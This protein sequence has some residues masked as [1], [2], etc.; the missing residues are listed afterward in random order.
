MSKLAVVVAS[1]RV[2]VI[3]AVAVPATLPSPPPASTSWADWLPNATLGA[4]V[5][6]LK[7]KAVAAETLPARS[8]WRTCT[9][10]APWL[11]VGAVV[12]TSATATLAWAIHRHAHSGLAPAVKS[13]LVWGLALT[14][15]LTLVTAG[16]LSGMGSHWVGGT[17]SD[18]GG[19]ALTGWS[20][21]GGDL[22][23]AHFFATHAMHFIPLAGWLLARAGGSAAPTLVRVTALAYSGFIAWTFMQALRGQPFL[24][25]LGT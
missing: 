17:P 11:G 9:E 14:L 10:L 21:D 8:L 13:G 4:P 18:A 16:T 19:L 12:L 2:S 15:P 1:L 24:A 3:V 5:S 20:R 25:G 6:K 7:L 22:R 23:V